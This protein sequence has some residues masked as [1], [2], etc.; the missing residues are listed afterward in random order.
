MTTIE[1]LKT[2]V[3]QELSWDPIVHAEKI[4]VSVNNG[5]VQLDGHVGSFYEKWAAEQAT[6]RVAKVKAVASEIKVD[7]PFTSTRTDQKIAETITDRMRWSYLIPETVGFQVADGWV[8]LEGTVKEY[9]QK[10]EAETLVRPLL[11]V[12][13]VTN[14]LS[15]ESR[16][17]A[18]DAQ[19]LIERAMERNTQLDSSH[20]RVSTS[21]NTV[22]LHGTVDSWRER[23]EAEYIAFGAPGVSKVE[24][25]I[26]IA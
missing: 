11:G 2:D 1:Q 8:T 12:K 17:I 7:L 13:G 24:N 18:T 6:F 23:E 19:W 4:G 9:F 5:V 10:K 22:M 15:M 14:E 25:Y 3:E 20:I 26:T 21:N 16:A